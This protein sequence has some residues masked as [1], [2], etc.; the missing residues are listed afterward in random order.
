MRGKVNQF[1]SDAGTNF[2]GATDD[3]K[4]N[5]INV[6]DETVK[7]F[8]LDTG[9]TWLF[10]TP[11]SSHMGGVWER[12][13]GTLRRILESMLVEVKNLTHEEL[14]TLMA[15]ISAIV[16]SRPLVPVS[17]D[18]EAPE[19]LTPTMLL[20][21]KSDADVQS[22]TQLDVKDLYRSQWK[23]VQ[24]LAY[25][26]WMRWQR[27]YLK[28]LQSRRKW[29]NEHKSLQVG[30]IVLMKNHEMGRL[31]WPIGLVEK[32]F[33]NEDGR[34]RKIE[35]RTARDGKVVNYVS[36]VQNHWSQCASSNY[37]WS[38]SVVML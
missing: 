14:V 5:T 36:V 30:D 4:I 20:T 21:Q 15:I 11:H 27:E 38:S 23:R 33:P 1:R 24:H 8:F 12:M 19:V 32:I 25:I 6:E 10:N 9:S 22:L 34:I 26:F 2:V 18:S 13:I 16:N 37:F 3:L 35:V 17:Y 31:Y 28:P 29:A 7:Q